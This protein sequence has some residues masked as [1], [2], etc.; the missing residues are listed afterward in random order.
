MTDIEKEA[1]EVVEKMNTILFDSYFKQYGIHSRDSI[2]D[3]ATGF[4]NLSFSSNG[5]E[6]VITFM[7]IP[8][9]D[10]I[11]DERKWTNSDED[12][13]SILQCVKREMLVYISIINNIKKVIKNV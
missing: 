1:L 7:N 10:S 12:K 4:V 13:E 2:C 5:E 3:N 9:W 6:C 11:N 8:L